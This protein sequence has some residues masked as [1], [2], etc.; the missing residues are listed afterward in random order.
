MNGTGYAIWLYGSHA[1]GVADS[2][3]D[4][5][6]LVAKDDFTSID[7][8]NSS[9]LFERRGATLSVYTWDEIMRMAEYGSLFLQHLKLEG[10]PIYETPSYRG[11]LRKILNQLADYTLAMRDLRG[12][13]VVLDDVEESL[14][15]DGEEIYELSVLGTVIRH[16]TILGCWL[17][18]RPSFGRLD[19]VS[20][21]VRLRGIDCA[22]ER[23]FPELYSFRLF[24]DGRIGKE[25]L[26]N[27]S[28]TRW[29]NRARHIVA[30]VG[31]LTNERN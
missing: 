24:A 15:N 8:I 18:N 7:N 19:P 17:L 2:H 26:R 4:L 30:K 3:S 13:N 10:I 23:E 29:L 1:R 31:E 11:Y 9:D 27:V 16:S 20:L 14:D 22:V 12:F 25:N 6:V 21:F 5:D 28:A